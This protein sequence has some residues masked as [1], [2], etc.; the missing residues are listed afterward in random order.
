MAGFA[1]YTARSEM[2][3][4]IAAGPIGRKC[5][6]SKGP[7]AG[8][9]AGCSAR[10]ETSDCATAPSTQV[11]RTIRRRRF[12]G[13]PWEETGD[14]TRAY[15]FAGAIIDAFTMGSRGGS[16]FRVPGARVPGSVRGFKVRFDVH[17]SKVWPACGLTV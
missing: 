8:A 16:R 17:G 11:A 15:K 9:G 2:R 10:P 4:D 3:P 13:I 12:I 5:R 6:L 1:S 7:A 14:W